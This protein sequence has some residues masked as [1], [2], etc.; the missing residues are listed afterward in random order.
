[1]SHRPAI[2]SRSWGTRFDSLLASTQIS[3]PTRDATLDSTAAD[4]AAAFVSSNE[5]KT[6]HDA[7]IFVGS[8][9]CNIDQADL[10]RLLSD[11]LAEHQEFRSIKVVRDS[12]GGICAFI[13]CEDAS[14]ASSLI[15]TLRSAPP[16]PFM[17]RILRYEPARAFRTLLISYR[18]PVQTLDSDGTGVRKQT[19]MLDLPYAMRLWK[20]KDSKYVN[21][22]YNAE[23]VDIEKRSGAASISDQG[24]DAHFFMHPVVFNAEA[25]RSIALFFGTLETFDRFKHD[26][27]TGPHIADANCPEKL[28]FPFPHNGARNSCMD[29]SCWEVKWRHRDDCVSALMALRRIPHLTV[30]WAHQPQSAIDRLAICHAKERK[31][32]AASPWSRTCERA[33]G[34]NLEEL[35]SS[36]ISRITGG[37]ESTMSSPTRSNEPVEFGYSRSIH[38]KASFD[39]D[40]EQ[41]VDAIRKVEGMKLNWSD[42]DFEPSTNIDTADWAAWQEQEINPPMGRKK[43]TI[44]RE[45]QFDV[46]S[47]PGLGMSPIT[48]KSFGSGFPSTPTDL[49]GELSGLPVDPKLIHD[50]RCSNV[51]KGKPVDP[52]TLFVGGL[53]MFGPGAWDEG[54]VRRCFEKYGALENVKFVRP[55][56]SCSAFAFVKFKSV[57]GP[58][59]AIREEHNRVYEGRAIR[60]QLRECNGSRGTWK[61]QRGRGRYN[62]S[63]AYP[64]KRSE[65]TPLVYAHRQDQTEGAFDGISGRRQMNID[66]HGIDQDARSPMIT[67]NESNLG[68]LDLPNNVAPSLHVEPVSGHEN[69]GYQTQELNPGSANTS[70]VPLSMPPFAYPGFGYYPAPW[71]HPYLQQVQY[72]FPYYAGYAGYMIPPP[73]LRPSPPSTT[74]VN[75]LGNVQ[76]PWLP[77]ANTFVPY[78]SYPPPQVTRAQVADTNAAYSQVPVVPSVIQTDQAP[79]T[80]EFCSSGTQATASQT[81]IPIWPH[82]PYP[83]PVP[84]PLNVNAKAFVPPLGTGWV[85][86]TS[87]ALIDSSQGLS[88][89]FVANARRQSGFKPF[90]AEVERATY[91]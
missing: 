13:Q 36:P 8:L 86:N 18:T 79:E 15:C 26:D 54:K 59:L 5:E 1:M 45:D 37:D 62:G 64:T 16:R 70:Q 12:K 75:A 53:E 81:N 21:I 71:F 87:G 29:K 57:D 24:S 77:P 20:A 19:V 30:T 91:N 44:E 74:D 42:E 38:Q 90:Y 69:E 11:H 41:G 52:T 76:T 55:Y 14:S 9:P 60:V 7:S 88:S 89:Q 49:S 47:T 73:M 39:Y 63:Y 23:A 46:A 84:G 67:Q 40:I 32:T 33:L 43:T 3:P 6:P 50:D 25:I 4:V 61:P 28:F 51:I 27:A 65:Q 31:S 80:N 82:Y 56:N 17:G 10:G 83:Y 72:Q 22:V 2:T 58:A 68:R 66:Q 48:P 85:P 78:I 34:P 35:S